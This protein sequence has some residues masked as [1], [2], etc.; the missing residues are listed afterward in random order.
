MSPKKTKPPVNSE[1]VEAEAPIRT[2]PATRALRF[3]LGKENAPE[4]TPVPTPTAPISDPQPDL[5]ISNSISDRGEEITNEAQITL[6]ASSNRA[7]SEGASSDSQLTNEYTPTSQLSQSQPPVSQLTDSQLLMSQPEPRPEWQPERASRQMEGQLELAPRRN[8][9]ATSSESNSLTLNWRAI[10]HTR[11]PQMVFDE[12]IPKLPPMAQMPYLQL[13]RLTLG[14]QRS[15]CHIS[16]EVWAS[17][18]NQSLASIKRQ[19]ALLQERGLL[20]KEHVIF[21]GAGRGSYYRPVIPGVLN[22]DPGNSGTKRTY[23]SG[24][25]SISSANNSVSQLTE[26]QLSQSQPPA[27]QLTGNYMKSDHDHD[28]KNINDHHEMQVMMTYKKLTGNRITKADQSAYQRVVHIEAETITLLMRQIYERSLEPIGS[29]AYF[30][31]AILNATQEQHRSRAAQK[32]SLERIVE[33]IRQ[34]RVGGRSALADLI[35]EIKRT[36]VRDNIIYNNDL[37]NEILGL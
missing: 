7:G 16:L 12:I 10:E 30:V 28:L 15:N 22:D 24:G 6:L 23:R 14:F 5:L 27:S 3:L 13:L 20:L 26:S 9:P 1:K 19:A 4:I 37:V 21:G 8:N 17:R 31:K 2:S 34:N 36:C 33:R 29:L 35:E 25:S 32:R 11:I 18:C